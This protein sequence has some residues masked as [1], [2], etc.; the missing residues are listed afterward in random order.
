MSGRFG[1]RYEQCIDWL[2]RRRRHC[3]LMMYADCQLLR[4]Y[5]YIPILRIHVGVSRKNDVNINDNK[6]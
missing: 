6:V 4:D 2:W 3:G 1:W 5:I